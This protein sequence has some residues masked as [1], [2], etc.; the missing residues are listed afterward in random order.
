[1]EKLFRNLFFNLG[2]VALM[3]FAGFNVAL[4]HGTWL[5]MLFGFSYF[6]CWIFVQYNIAGKPK[7]K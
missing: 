7:V 4:H 5:V 3:A 6:I 1:M 2:V